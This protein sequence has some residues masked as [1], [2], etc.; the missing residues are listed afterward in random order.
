MLFPLK[1]S[2]GPFIIVASEI[3]ALKESQETF[4]SVCCLAKPF[5]ESWPAATLRD[6]QLSYG[7]SC[8]ILISRHLAGKK[9]F[10]KKKSLVWYCTPEEKQNKNNLISYILIT[11]TFWGPSFSPYSPQTRIQSIEPSMKDHCAIWK[12]LWTLEELSRRMN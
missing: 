6:T 4:R 9:Y 5:I 8:S 11:S 10:M 2:T 3:K 12:E 1:E 7:T